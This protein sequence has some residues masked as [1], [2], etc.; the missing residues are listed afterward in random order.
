MS[1]RKGGMYFFPCVLPL[2]GIHVVMARAKAATLGCEILGWSTMHN[3]VKRVV[4]SILSLTSWRTI[5]ENTREFPY[6]DNYIKRSKLLSCLYDLSRWVKSRGGRFYHSQPNPIPNYYRKYQVGAQKQS[7]VMPHAV[8]LTYR[9]QTESLCHLWET[10]SG[11]LIKFFTPSSFY[12]SSCPFF[13]AKASSRCSSHLSLLSP[14]G[15]QLH[16]AFYSCVSV[17]CLG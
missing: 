1:L 7:L 12:W 2:V 4:E 17:C 3:R 9:V 8:T 5:P 14:H 16:S 15:T 10:S 13:P 6:L 11:R